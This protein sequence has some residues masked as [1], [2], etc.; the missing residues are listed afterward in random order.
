[1]KADRQVTAMR[2][3]KD[4]KSYVCADGREILHGED[5]DARRFELLQRSRGQCE[6]IIIDGLHGPV[7]CRRDANDPHHVTLRSVKRNDK[8]SEL[9]ALCRH[10]HNVLDREQRKAKIAA[11]DARR[12][13]PPKN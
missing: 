10:H 4:P 12:A 13:Q 3:F 9:L 1:M 8:L 6:Y 7:R 2:K 11:R 5:W